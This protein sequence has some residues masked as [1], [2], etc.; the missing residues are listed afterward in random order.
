MT[1]A[2]SLLVRVVATLHLLVLVAAAATSTS[3][4]VINLDSI[5][6]YHGLTGDAVVSTIEEVDDIGGRRIDLSASQLAEDD[7]ILLLKRVL[8]QCVGRGV[9]R[10][11]NADGGDELPPLSATVKNLDFSMNRLSPSGMV[12]V[13]NEISQAQGDDTD[14]PH[15]T[16]SAMSFALEEL[17]LS[18]NDFGGHG[19]NQPEERLIESFRKLFESRSACAPRS[20]VL[21]NCSIGPAILRSIGRVCTFERVALFIRISHTTFTIG[22]TEQIRNEF[23]MH[24]KISRPWGE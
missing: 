9:E 11:N 12:A 19:A 10:D 3:T 20:L 17:D 22:Y 1:V 15:G 21:Q 2:S 24:D 6:T 4:G 14:E 13:I 18:M 5:G 16:D 7:V 23:P 8:L